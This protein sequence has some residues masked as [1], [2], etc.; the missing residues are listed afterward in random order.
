[1][2]DAREVLE[3]MR[4]VARTR[5]DMLKNG[6]TFHDEPNRLYYLQEYQDRLSKIEDIIRRQS[7]R[8][9]RDAVDEQE[10]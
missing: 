5:I 4:E 6:V 1:M 7:I 9:V 10:K 3:M 8:I 2:A